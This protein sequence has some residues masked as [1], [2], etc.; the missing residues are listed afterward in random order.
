MD[1]LIIVLVDSPASAPVQAQF[2]KSVTWRSEDD[3]PGG[4]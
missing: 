2:T 4:V 3:S 1:D